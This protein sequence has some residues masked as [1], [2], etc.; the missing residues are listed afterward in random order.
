[1]L[2]FIFGSRAKYS[3]RKITIER[4]LNNYIEMDN[5]T[6]VDAWGNN[7]KEK[8]YNEVLAYFRDIETNIKFKTKIDL[9]GLLSVPNDANSITVSAIYSVLHKVYFDKEPS[10]KE[11][12]KLMSEYETERNS[13][14]LDC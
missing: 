2:E 10:Q 14:G 5:G 1:M 11:L 8:S 3:M 13:R 9:L 12:K 7:W 4:Y 6:K